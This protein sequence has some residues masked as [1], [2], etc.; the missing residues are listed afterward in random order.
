MFSQTASTTSGGP[1]AVA[2]AAAASPD[3]RSSLRPVAIDNSEWADD[4]AW[5]CY[6]QN[7][8]SWEARGCPQPGMHSYTTACRDITRVISYQEG[9]NDKDA[10]IMFGELADGSVFHL[11]ASCDYTGFGCQGGGTVLFAPDWNNLLDHASAKDLR[12][13]RGNMS[14]DNPPRLRQFLESAQ[15]TEELRARLQNVLS[16][17]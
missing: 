1:G 13:L 8:G 17:R 11:W 7:V 6:N 5:S 4:V 14:R 9:V 16:R 10:W 2:P 12:E 15:D 3:D